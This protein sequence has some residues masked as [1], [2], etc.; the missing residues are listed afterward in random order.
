[1]KKKWLFS[2]VFSLFFSIPFSVAHGETDFESDKIVSENS[3]DTSSSSKEQ[4]TKSFSNSSSE[5][6]SDST[7]STEINNTDVDQTLEI[8]YLDSVVFYTTP[9]YGTLSPRESLYYS[10]AEDAK[11]SINPIDGSSYLD[12]ILKVE[13][14]FKFDTNKVVFAATTGDNQTLFIH[15]TQL[16]RNESNNFIT[17]TSGKKATIY[18]NH[19]L[20]ES[21]DIDTLINR[22][23]Q[24]QE[25]VTIKNKVFLSLLDS[26]DNLVGFIEKGTFSET[27]NK[28]GIYTNFNRFINITTQNQNIYS[29]FEWKN[30]YN[31]T[32]FI[33]NTFLAKGV[34]YHQ[35]GENYL[36]LYDSKDIWIGYINEKFITESNTRFGNSFDYNQFVTITSNNYDIY[37]DLNWNKKISSKDVINHTF[38]AKELYNHFNGNQY[39]AIY[40]INNQLYGYINQSATTK[41]DGPQG[42][43]HNFNKY[44]TVKSKNYQFYNNFQWGFR[45]NSSSY[46]ENTYQARGIYY[47]QNGQSYL[48]VYDSKGKW[49]GYINKN[50]MTISESPQGAY[51]ALDKYATVTS[52]NYDIWQ[53]FSWKKKTHSKHYTKQTLFV[54]G[55]YHHFNG[56][57]YYSIF[58]NKNQWIGYI[59]NNA[60]TLA[61][62]AQGIHHSYG[63][64]VTFSSNYPVWRDFDWKVQN[65]NVNVKGKTFLAKGVYYH[66]NGSSYYSIYNGNTWIGYINSNAAQN[67]DM[68][69]LIPDTESLLAVTHIVRQKILDTSNNPRSVIDRVLAMPTVNRNQITY[70]DNYFVVN[71]K[72]KNVGTDEVKL[73]TKEIVP[74]VNYKLLP[75]DDIKGAIPKLNNNKKY[76][77]LTFDDGP[78]PITTPQLLNIL[79]QKNV[80]ASFFMLGNGVNANPSVAKRVANEGH[81]IAS[82][83]YSHPQLT[84][85]SSFQVEK[86]MRDADKAIYFAT[87]QL[88]S[89]F[90]PPYGA[91]NRSVSNTV[92]KPAIMWSIDT[93]DWESRNPTAINNIVNQNIHNGAI[94][95]L[96]DIHQP[97]VN[98]VPQMI[99]NL[100]RKGYEFVTIDEL[101]EMNQRPLHGYFNRTSNVKY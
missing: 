41:A 84:S 8:N 66:Y 22:T 82:H 42:I 36:S 78:S 26:Q 72:G 86:Q 24:I 46:F 35:N 11:N 50:A 98:S 67:Y 73:T 96:H 7:E 85:L 89:T 92:S 74:A 28:Q 101:L 53:N 55:K 81:Q 21:I 54:K 31:S 99:D 44:V 4:S 100:R 58:N 6:I 29:N 3:I 90:R 43:Y 70:R 57:I 48:S 2:A 91:I 64:N 1:M 40:D 38:T 71:L 77:A 9:F 59:N 75:A 80:K 65:T 61:D 14:E 16:V 5:Q 18:N 25:E 95:L 94:I 37:S 62:G 51:K 45:S 88:P 63:K 56:G 32:N 39:L 10:S 97:S 19:S 87:G 68:N 23:Y 27:K 20:N 93:R 69:K 34:Y 12:K 76:V 30:K 17:L 33:N 52:N 79:K 60:M 15:S 47:H 49:L 83:S 13:Q